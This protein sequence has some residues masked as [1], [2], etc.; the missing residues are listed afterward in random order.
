MIMRKH[1][2]QKNKFSDFEDFCI[3]NDLEY[4]LYPLNN[5]YCESLTFKLKVTGK[6]F[7]N[8]YC[9]ECLPGDLQQTVNDYLTTLKG[10]VKEDNDRIKLFSFNN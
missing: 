8:T 4:W 10:L 6:E 9:F 3:M 1:E 2:N 7:S 5:I